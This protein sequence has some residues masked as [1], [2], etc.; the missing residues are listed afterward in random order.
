MANILHLNCQTIS[1]LLKN[2]IKNYSM[3]KKR[4]LSSI[5]YSKNMAE[6]KPTLCQHV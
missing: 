2:K 3:M 5:I 6:L 4:N 1:L